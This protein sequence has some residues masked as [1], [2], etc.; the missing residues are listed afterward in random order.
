MNFAQT[1]WVLAFCA[2]ALGILS[3]ALEGR[4][5]QKFK[6]ALPYPR[7]V[8]DAPFSLHEPSE[9]YPAELRRS[10]PYRALMLVQSLVIVLLVILAIVSYKHDLWRSI[11]GVPVAFFF[12]HA[13]ARIPSTLAL[14]RTARQEG[15]RPVA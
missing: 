1:N 12:A 3:G 9:G 5:I 11:L 4:A 8:D 13:V 7:A 6:E 14:R 2:L 10:A 15:A